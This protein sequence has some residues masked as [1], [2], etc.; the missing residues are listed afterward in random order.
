ME[1]QMPVNFLVSISLLIIAIAFW[2]LGLS[3][4]GS[5]YRDLDGLG[6]TLLSLLCFA[7]SLGV[8]LGSLLVGSNG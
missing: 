8:S 3:Y 4:R 1:D 2:F 7:L 6:Y 5:S